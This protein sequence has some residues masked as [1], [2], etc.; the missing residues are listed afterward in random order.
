MSELRPLAGRLVVD[1]SQQLP[2]PFATLLLR[3]F[4]ARVVKVEPPGG[5]TGLR[6]DPELYRRVTA[7][8]EL[9]TLDL[10]SEQ[11]RAELHRLVADADVFVE[12]FRPGVTARL[13]A[14]YETLS[15]LNP[16]L[17]YCSISG[18]GPTG[19]LVASPGH[20]LNY[21]ALSGGLPDGL[22]E[23]AALIRVPWVDLATATNAALAILA[24]I[25][26]RG[27]GGAGRQL[28]IAMLD[29]AAV[30]S[31]AKPP[32]P[33]AEGSYGIFAT[34]DGERVA[35]SVLEQDMWERLCE[36]LGWEDWLADPGFAGNDER[37]AR[38]E[39]VEARLREEIAARSAAEMID[40]AGRHDL[41]ISKVNALAEA[42]ADPQL[43]ERDVFPTEGSWRLLGQ[44]AAAVP[45]KGPA[46]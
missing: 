5:E 29:A 18:Y 23:G 30:W 35:V 19:P 31:A 42:A 3:T 44:L 33:G 32:R 7:D 45:F 14:D 27:E 1:V 4:G 10:K 40:L 2:G 13:A 46:V 41:P 21:L 34:A 38:A 9:V 16:G 12:G 25:I 15:A 20:D 28:E 43:R 37:R 17:I 6:V 39:P 26:E 22:P 24:A 36:A 8:K 11:G